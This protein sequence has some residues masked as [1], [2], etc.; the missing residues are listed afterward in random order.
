M[1]DLDA[2]ERAAR[3]ATPGPWE[4]GEADPEG[5]PYVGARFQ[6]EIY[7]QV[8]SPHMPRA[9]CE[10]IA[11]AAFV[12]LA[13]PAA[14]LDLIARQRAAEAA[15]KAIHEFCEDGDGWLHGHDG[16]DYSSWTTCEGRDTIEAMASDALKAL[17]IPPPA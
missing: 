7:S 2:I 14:I 10:T 5:I 17:S 11:D 9:G 8:S 6:D 13:N 3:A 1:I 16:D 12:A 15:L 4:T